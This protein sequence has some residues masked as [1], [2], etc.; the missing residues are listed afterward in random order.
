MNK[1]GGSAKKFITISV[2]LGA[3]LIFF[4]LLV[5]GIS[6]YKFAKNSL[7]KTTERLKKQCA[8]YDSVLSADKAKSLIRITEQT[9]EI[10]EDIERNPSLLTADYLKDYAS[11]QRLSGIMI[12]NEKLELELEYKGRE[13]GYEDWKNELSDVSTANICDYPQKIYSRRVIQNGS[14]YDTAMVCRADK[15]GIVCC[16]RYQDSEILSIN[17]SY[18]ANV[19]AGYEIENG[20]I[21]FITDGRKI[22][23]TNLSELQDSK[24]DNS[25]LIKNLDSAKKAETAIV[26]DE[27]KSYFGKKT[28]CGEYEL[29]AFYPLYNVFAPGLRLTAMFFACYVLLCM[30]IY[31]LRE[32]AVKRNAV[33]Y[34]KRLELATQKAVKA[35]EEKTNFLRR[36]SHDI[37]TPI[38]VIMGMT[39][40]AQRSA[41]DTGKQQYCLEKIQYASSVLLDLV[42]DVLM[43]NKIE[44]QGEAILENPF[45]L[46]AVFAQIKALTVPE[47]ENNG[48]KLELNMREVR[49]NELYGCCAYLRQIAV[50]IINNAVKYTPKGGEVN[51]Y[52][53]EIPTAS[54]ELK[55]RFVCK[56]NG[57]GMSKEFQ[58]RMFEPFER[59]NKAASSAYEGTG[60]GLAIVKNLVGKLNGKIEVESEK[61]KGTC[62]KVEIP[63]KINDL[64]Q[65]SVKKSTATNNAMLDGMSVLVAE[66]SELNMEIAE[67]ILKE[68]GAKVTK[69]GN[70]AEALKIWNNS[71]EDEF[72]VILMD[73][74]MPVMNRLTAAKKI[75]SSDRKD[76]K[77]V[78]IIAMSANVFKEDIKACADAGMSDYISKPIDINKIYEILMRVRNKGAV[79]NEF[80]GT[81]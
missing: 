52:F 62:F 22:I 66:D 29:Y 38:N 46:D 18:I 1:T 21:V 60:L 35:N 11:D 71:A 48:V 10:C 39:E 54:E 65:N 49:H 7:Y 44:T 15:K 16:Y 36:V 30:L 53:E 31:N 45:G 5:C 50:N 76:A 78:A 34:R 6:D 28:L 51:A 69:A 64:A 9:N 41:E 55:I 23:G 58:K 80:R 3:V 47:A 20:G 8:S 57:T 43:F 59:E 2:S 12:L 42:D 73:L 4:F 40:I 74:M 81:L 72:D 56:D 19:M 33:E 27:N 67:F 17:A 63:F 75:R 77:S 24:T 25:A 26:K 37:R 70:G 13:I 32:H 61:G 79:K 68:K 14:Y